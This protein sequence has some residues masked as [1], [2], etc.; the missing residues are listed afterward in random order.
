M[1]APLIAAIYP[2]SG[3]TAVPAGAT[4]QITFDQGIDIKSISECIVV[5]GPDF[6]K[7]SG[8]ESATWIDPKSGDNLF[9]L[10][11]PGFTGSVNCDVKL[12]YVDALGNEVTGLEILT[13]ADEVSA[14]VVSKVIIT[15]KSLMQSEVTYHV[16]LVGE[17]S[18]GTKR[19]IS[20]RTVFDVDSSSAISTDGIVKVY[21]GYSGATDDVLNVQ[22]TSSG[23]IGSAKYKWWLT[24]EGVGTAKTGNVTSR[25]FRHVDQDLGLQ[26]KFDGSDFIN[27]DIYTV[28]LRAPV[29]MANTY[30]FSFTIGEGTIIEVPSTAST[31]VIGT[32]SSLTSETTYLEVLEMDPP[33]TST[34]QR[35]KHR[36]I[37]ITFSEELNP[38]T[39]TQDSVTVIAYPVSGKFD[40]NLS[41]T[42]EPLELAKK[43]SVVSN[44]LIIEV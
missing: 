4:I 2:N 43:L 3:A 16:Y 23:N 7:T 20:H 39:V 14:G 41:N 40:S 10:S 38:T 6:D 21:G 17:S 44:K 27:G 18:D 9:F 37:T 32:L 28:N 1:T 34:H 36:K 24:S 31:S 11:S 8:P 5:Y 26:I 15:P 13:P 35:F 30:S 25:R 19:G 12:I 42:S 33:D 29:L 22:I